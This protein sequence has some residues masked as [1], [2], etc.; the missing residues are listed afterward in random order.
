VAA[1]QKYYYEVTAINSVGQS[2][3]SNE[4][5]ATLLSVGKLMRVSITTN[6]I[7]YSNSQ[8]ATI[9]VSVK[10]ASTGLALPGAEV[11]IVLMNSTNSRTYSAITSPNGQAQVT[12][13]LGNMKGN[14]TVAASVTLN[15]YQT[16]SAQTY[17]N[18]T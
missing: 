2:P 16:G 17:V 1:G 3:K 7:T 5:N 13:S 14:Y 12:V 15:G 9:T 4:A 10:D 11:K 8:H 18:I 6:R